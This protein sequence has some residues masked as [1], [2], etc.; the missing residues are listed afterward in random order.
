MKYNVLFHAEH[1]PGVDNGTA[2]TLSRLQFQEFR[3]LAPYAD[4]SP[5]TM[6]PYI[7]PQ[8]LMIN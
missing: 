8:N 4:E 1:V 2:D 7:Q 3:Q 5:I 6:A